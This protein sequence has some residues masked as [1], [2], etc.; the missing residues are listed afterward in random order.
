MESHLGLALLPSRLAGTVLG[1][2]GLLGLVLAAVGI[3]GVMSYSV[4]QRTREIGIRMAIGAA[5]GEV[6]ALM[7]R[8]GLRLVVVGGAI[9]LLLSLA[10][11]R[12]VRGVLYGSNALDPLTFVA[13]PLVLL[14]VAAAAIWIPARRASAVEPVRALHAE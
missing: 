10:A 4:S 5:R 3:Y 8:Q 7:M 11:S 9:G 12:L 6:V 13:V 2:F 1:I 14:A